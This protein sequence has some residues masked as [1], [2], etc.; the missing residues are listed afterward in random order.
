MR[1][2]S[3]ISDKKVQKNSKN[4]WQIEIFIIYYTSIS[5]PKEEQYGVKI[6]GIFGEAY[7]RTFV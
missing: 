1:T 2:K 7:K 6:F 5:M 4:P 3:G